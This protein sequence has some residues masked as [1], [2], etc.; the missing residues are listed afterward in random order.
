MTV[1]SFGIDILICA[2]F[3]G[4]GFLVVHTFLSDQDRFTKLALSFGVGAGVTSWSLFVLS[5]IG[6][7]LSIIMVSLT[8]ISLALIWVLPVVLRRTSSLSV[9]K[10]SELILR[11]PWENVVSRSILLA[12]GIL[13]GFNVLVSV[14]LSY[15]SWDGI[16]IWGVKGYGIAS[17]GTIFAA[18]E[19]GQTGTAFPMNIP[20][21]IAIY[22]LLSGD[23]LPGSKMIFS[24]F[25]AS[26][27]LGTYRVLKELQVSNLVSL[28]GIF[29]LATT[30]IVFQHATIAYT[31]LPFTFYICMGTFWGLRGLRQEKMTEIVFAGLLMALA[32]WTRPEGIVLAASLLMVMIL[33]QI[34]RRRKIVH[35]FYAAVPIIL[36]M[37]PWFVFTAL[38]GTITEEF[39][40]VRIAISGILDGV[41]H[42]HGLMAVM[43]FLAGQVV[44]YRDFGFTLA[45]ILGSILLGLRYIKNVASD[46]TG[47]LLM[48]GLV[49]GLAVIGVHYVF[50][51]SPKEDYVSVM[52]YYAFTRNFL[53]T[54][55]VLLWAGLKIISLQV[56]R[57]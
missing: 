30:P 55:V 24:L 38:H 25:F 34:L 5:F 54:M 18:S 21:Q 27:L 57:T 1:V 11:P 4:I 28:I 6:L 43:R 53:P 22:K 49:L 9:H 26:L 37:A 19:W 2:S 10:S 29:I 50:T 3:A 14:G 51:Y 56:D 40:L 31:N 35:V 8:F 32:S 33:V 15:Y 52:L 17:E 7:K 48:A 12:V 39:G 47:E 13:I 23:L 45:I 36:I 20:I 16:A 41:F 46:L 44:R 42:W